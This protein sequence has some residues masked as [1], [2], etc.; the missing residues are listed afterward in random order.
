MKMTEHRSNSFQCVLVT[1]VHNICDSFFYYNSLSIWA[2]LMV[3]DEY[4][5][6]RLYDVTV[7]PFSMWSKHSA[8]TALWHM[9]NKKQKRE[10]EGGITASSADFTARRCLFFGRISTSLMLLSPNMQ[11]YTFRIHPSLLS[12]QKGIWCSLLWIR[13]LS[14]WTENIDTVG[15]LQIGKHSDIYR[16]GYFKMFSRSWK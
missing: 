14:S 12:L 7:Q 2:C 11:V 16:T 1:S 5:G 10:G 8:V 4:A 13:A 3:A 9:D 15:W 6:R